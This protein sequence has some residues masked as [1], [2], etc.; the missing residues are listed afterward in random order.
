MQVKLFSILYSTKKIQISSASWPCC[1]CTRTVM[2]VQS[3]FHHPNQH[4]HLCIEWRTSHVLIKLLLLQHRQCSHCCLQASWSFLFL[5]QLNPG[6]IPCP[7]P[8]K[9][10]WLVPNCLLQLN[11]RVTWEMFQIGGWELGLQFFFSSQSTTK[12]IRT[13]QLRHT[14]AH[15]QLDLSLLCAALW[16]TVNP[17]MLWN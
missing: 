15:F 9:G 12:R 16:F 11:K 6:H 4:R 8:L 7:C 10:L 5:S 17:E 13:W 14:V 3:L 2:F 1:N